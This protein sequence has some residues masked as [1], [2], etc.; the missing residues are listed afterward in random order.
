MMWPDAWV[1]SP[2]FWRRL[3]LLAALL[4]DLYPNVGGT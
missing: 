2:A 4:G 1:N 3:Q